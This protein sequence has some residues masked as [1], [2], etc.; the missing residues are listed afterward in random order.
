VAAF[1]AV[2]QARLGAQQG[3]AGAQ[4]SACRE[5]RPAD[6]SRDEYVAYGM[7]AALNR[8]APLPE[9]TYQAALTAFGQQGLAEIVSLVGCFSPAPVGKFAAAIPASSATRPARVAQ[10]LGRVSIAYAPDSDIAHEHRRSMHQPSR[11][12]TPASW[13]QPSPTRRSWSNSLPARVVSRLGWSSR[14]A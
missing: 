9:T 3:D 13:R 6:L 12:A 4:H 2:R 5:E 10:D 7:A 8:G 1:S 11:P 14:Q